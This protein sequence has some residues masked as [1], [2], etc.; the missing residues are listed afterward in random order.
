M[1]KK[2]TIKKALKRFQNALSSKTIDLQQEIDENVAGADSLQQDEIEDI[3]ADDIAFE[4]Q[5]NIAQSDYT[6]EA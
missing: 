5:A 2:C 3:Q 4:Q 6:S 1:V